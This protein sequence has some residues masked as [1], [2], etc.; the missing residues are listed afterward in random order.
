MNF[1]EAALKMDEGCMVRRPHW[2]RGYGAWADKDGAGIFC[3]RGTGPAHEDIR[4]VD[5][6][7]TDWEVV[8]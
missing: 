1:I 5:C 2:P 4:T 8:P 7:A 6:L 3:V